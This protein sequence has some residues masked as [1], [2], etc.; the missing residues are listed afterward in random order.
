MSFNVMPPPTTV[1]FICRV[2]CRL[3]GAYSKMLGV[4]RNLFLVSWVQELTLTQS[5][6]QVATHLPSRSSTEFSPY[7]I[8]SLTRN[9]S[10]PGL[11]CIGG[12]EEGDYRG[13]RE[14][15]LAVMLA[16]RHLPSQLLASPG[17]RTGTP[18]SSTVNSFLLESR[19]YILTYLYRE[20]MLDEN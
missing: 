8:L 5:C 17:E 7:N 2:A 18:L 9:A 19:I 12:K 6:G 16:C 11:V 13:E 14:H 15:A 1:F 4:V 10:R 3:Q 20:Q